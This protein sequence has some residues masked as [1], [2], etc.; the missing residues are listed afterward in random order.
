MG[1]VRTFIAV[2][3]L[4]AVSQASDALARPHTSKRSDFPAEAYII[5]ATTLKLSCARTV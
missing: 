2:L 1:C 5:N 3:A 4:I